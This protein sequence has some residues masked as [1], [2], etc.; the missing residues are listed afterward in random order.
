MISRTNSRLERST[1]KSFTRKQKLTLTSLA[2]ADFISFCSMS[3]MAPFFPREAAEKGLSD[4]L[5]GFIFSFY[6]L[7]VFL[8]SPIFGK[9]VSYLNFD[10]LVLIRTFSFRNLVLKDSFYPECLWQVLVTCCLRLL[11][12]SQ[13][14][15]C[16]QRFVL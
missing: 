9:I 6:A 5:S 15:R 10:D 12:M 13:T 1:F 4:T 14:I 11:N 16:L 7:V 2:L 8:T 3:I